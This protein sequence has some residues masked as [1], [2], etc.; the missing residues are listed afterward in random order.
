[1]AR[2]YPTL[3]RR[4]GPSAG[5][6]FVGHPARAA[7][8]SRGVCLVLLREP[9]GAQQALGGAMSSPELWCVVWAT[10]SSAHLAAK[11][12]VPPTVSE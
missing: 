9:F 7:R 11:S 2:G 3:V 10:G 5:I 6:V 4:G 1:M 12:F 8:R